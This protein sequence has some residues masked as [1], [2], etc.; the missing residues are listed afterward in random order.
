[1]HPLEAAAMADHIWYIKNCRL[2]EQLSEQQ[3]AQLERSSRVRRFPKG[4]TIYLPS[5][6]GSG[7]FLLAEGRV[8]LCSITPDGKQAILAF[9]EPG[10][11][12]GELALLEES[13]REEHAEAMVAS[14]LVLMPG[15]ALERLMSESAALAIGVTKLIGLRRKRIER[16]L[17]SLLFRSNR[18]RLIHL[19][20][21]LSSQ[22][23][24]P[25]KDGTL[26]AI[27]LSHQDLASIIGATRETVT[28]LLGELQLERL[29]KVARQRLVVRDLG[30]LA[31][32]VQLRPPLLP[33]A[34]EK[35][36]G[37]ERDGQ[38]PLGAG[39]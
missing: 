37:L 5:D 39:P 4:T 6:A 22:Y 21:D 9:I 16:R 23:G 12:F 13:E 24:Q 25:D 28:T 14:T 20:L 38:P 33:A 34:Q 29:L 10:E 15:D 11:L 35:P 1:M 7:V 18:D 3:L 8:K 2:F 17:K 36:I 32:C 26:L 19:L 27:P 31:K 30:R